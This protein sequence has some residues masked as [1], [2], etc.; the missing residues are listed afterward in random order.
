MLL[1]NNII[2]FKKNNKHPCS[3]C[4]LG[5]II[6]TPG[7][8]DI[9]FKIYSDKNIINYDFIKL[10]NPVI[11]YKTIDI[12]ANVLTKINITIKTNVPNDL[13]CLIFD[14]FNSEIYI[15]YEDFQVVQEI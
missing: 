13:L 8:Y 2:N 10:H 6:E 12:H 9:S 14:N 5:Y 15:K 3:H 11:F 4:W 7:L 1:D